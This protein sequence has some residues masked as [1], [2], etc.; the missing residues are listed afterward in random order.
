MQHIVT[1]RVA[2]SVCRSICLSIGLSL[3]WTWMGPR[4]CYIWC[5]LVQLG[6]YDWTVRMRWRCG[7][8]VKFLTPL[9]FVTALYSI[10]CI[11]HIYTCVGQFVFDLCL[12]VFMPL[13]LYV[14][15]RWNKYKKEKSS[16]CWLSHTYKWTYGQLAHTAEAFHVVIIMVCPM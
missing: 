9:V 12:R 8:F 6:E 11:V 3:L 10:F 4:M 1:D 5:A 16:V 7:L 2:W 14:L 15:L 13:Y